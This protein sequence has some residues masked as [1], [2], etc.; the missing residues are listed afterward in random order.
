MNSAELEVAK[1][2]CPQGTS[3]GLDLRLA[4]GGKVAEL[5]SLCWGVRGPGKGASEDPVPVGPPARRPRAR[6]DVLRGEPA[7]SLHVN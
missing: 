7:G 5:R 4:A 2:Q 1:T 3:P 6:V